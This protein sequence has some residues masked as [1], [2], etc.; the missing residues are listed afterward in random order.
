MRVAVGGLGV[1]VLVG[2]EGEDGLLL[3]EQAVISNAVTAKTA[4]DK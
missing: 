3:V 4:T 1:L 2:L